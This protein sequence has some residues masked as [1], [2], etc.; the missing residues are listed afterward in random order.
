MIEGDSTS[1]E[2]L[3]QVA[4]VAE[5]KETILV[6]LD[7]NHTHDHVL[8]EMELYSSFV[9]KGSYLVVF[10]TIIEEMPDEIF[11]DRPW[12]KGNSPKTAVHRFLRD[13]DEFII[14]RNIDNKLLITVAPEGYLK[15]VK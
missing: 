11:S 7:S 2:V 4:M 14:D 3:N 6:C 5:D 15:R 8:K 1:D 9:S 12:G 13:H 10:D